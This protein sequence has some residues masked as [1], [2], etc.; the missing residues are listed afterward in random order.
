MAGAAP[1][2]TVD[3]A[4]KGPVFREIFVLYLVTLLAIRAVV[5]L[6]RLAGVHELIL[7]LVP[8]LFMYA[9]VW[10]CRWRGVD[11][12]D[13]PLEVPAFR[14]GKAWLRPLLP[15]VAF[16]AAITVPFVFGYHV[17]QTMGVPMVE[18]AL[19]IR[20]YATRPQ[21]QWTWPAWADFARLVGYQVFFVAIPEEFFYRGYMQTRL[22]EAWGRPWKVAGTYVGPG[23]LITC[24]LFAFGHSLVILQWWHVFI[25]FP[26]LAFGWLRARTGGVLAGAYFH[27]YCN[28]GVGVLDTLY[29]IPNGMAGS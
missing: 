13:Y 27:A 8:V 1:G 5:D 2:Q 20:L 15:A 25:V 18:D 10:L 17:W 4:P 28:L 14:D 26:S 23:L 12:W 7:A 3:L 24:V 29:G 21:L 22:D 16:A 9:P 6:Q 11:S 19:N